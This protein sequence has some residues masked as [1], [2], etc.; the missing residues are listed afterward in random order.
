[1][2]DDALLDGY[3]NL[4]LRRSQKR[5]GVPFD[6]PEA[7]GLAA[8]A[9][10][11]V[12]KEG[13][14]LP[15]SAVRLQALDRMTKPLLEGREPQ[16]LAVD[17]AAIAW[18]EAY[19]VLPLRQPP[20]HV[21]AWALACGGARGAISGA[22]A[23]AWRCRFLTGAWPLLD[24]E[25]R[26]EAARQ[27]YKWQG[28]LQEKLEFRGASA[29]SGSIDDLRVI[30]VAAEIAARTG[31]GELLCAARRLL[32]PLLEMQKS[33]GRLVV[34]GNPAA[35]HHVAQFALAAGLLGHS[36]AA[37]SAIDFLC[38]SRRHRSRPL[39]L[40]HDSDPDTVAVSPWVPLALAA[41]WAS[42][43]RLLP[44]PPAMLAPS[45]P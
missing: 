2:A 21:L 1:M 37:G 24:S 23:S 7:T 8:V 17:T 33:D 10:V 11:R 13:A 44:S 34:E 27:L 32:R 26:V 19:G 29:N 4:Y 22:I 31:G 28:Y 15:D 38:R 9:L 5:R 43:L 18:T 20:T 39:L 45:E 16:T 25:A 30:P 3:A 12:T 40:A 35:S 41:H 14:Q 6:R 36:D 42:D